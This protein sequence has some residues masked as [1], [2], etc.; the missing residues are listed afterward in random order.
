MKLKFKSGDTV[1]PNQEQEP[2]VI[3][4]AKK[5]FATGKIIYV[6]GSGQE[7]EEGTLSRM[8]PAK[9]KKS[10]KA[11]Q[12][13]LDLR[14]VYLEKVGEEVASNKKN[15]KVWMAEKI[16][17]AIADEDE[18]EEEPSEYER[19]VAL[20]DEELKELIKNQELDIDTAD[21]ET[22]DEIRVAIC[23]VL[24]IEIPSTEK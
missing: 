8:K 16:A 12:E 22:T 20:K 5:N 3:K 10:K 7:H 1:Y 17:E 4:V 9:G 21:Y 11:D 23:E 15:D 18:N 14:A 2:Q 13:T 6:M 24:E 19:I